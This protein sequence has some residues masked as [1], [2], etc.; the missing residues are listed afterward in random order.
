MCSL[1]EHIEIDRYESEKTDIFL[2]LSNYQ[3]KVVLMKN[4]KLALT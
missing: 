1:K 4:S 2:R 3:D